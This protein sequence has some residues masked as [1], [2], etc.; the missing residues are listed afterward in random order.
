MN[1]PASLPLPELAKACRFRTLRRSGPGGQHRNKV[2]TAVIVTHIPSGVS[3][4]ANERRSQDENRQQAMQRLR[5]NLALTIRSD[6][7]VDSQPTALWKSRTRQGRIAVNPSHADFPAVLAEALDH[8]ATA[9]GDV[10]AAA[11]SLGCSASQLV[12]LFKIEPRA[13]AAVNAARVQ[14]GQRPLK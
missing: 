3:A 14:N 5:V 8:V 7:V 10:K 9:A 11:E 6:G 13:F 2:E 12:K 4:E 1:H